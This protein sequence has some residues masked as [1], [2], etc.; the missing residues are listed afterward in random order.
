MNK[1][2]R[3]YILLKIA[4]KWEDLERE[5][6]QYKE[7][8]SLAKKSL[9]P[10]YALWVLSQLKADE[11]IAEIISLISTFEKRKGSLRNKDL[12]SYK[13]LGD[14]RG[15]IEELGVSKRIKIEE[16]KDYET[17]YKD[18]RFAIRLPKTK[19]GSCSLGRGTKWCISATESENYF[20][21]YS[22]AN[23]YIYFVFDKL[24]LPGTT[25]KVAFCY[26]KSNVQTLEPEYFDAKD[27]A[28]KY[29][30]IKNIYGDE[31]S[32]IEGLILSNLEG[33]E[34]TDVK[35]YY[36]SM[37]LD[38][39]VRTWNE[40][41]ESS[42]DNLGTFISS[43]LR[44]NPSNEICRFIAKNLHNVELLDSEGEIPWE[45]NIFYSYLPFDKIKEF[46]NNIN[47]PLLRDK[48]YVRVAFQY[49]KN[50]PETLSFE[51]VKDFILFCDKGLKNGQY[52]SDSSIQYLDKH[53]RNLLGKCS[54]TKDNLVDLLKIKGLDNSIRS[55]LLYIY[56]NDQFPI[57]SAKYEE[58]EE[59]EE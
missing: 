42:L 12:Y 11:P 16:G 22:A 21:R 7:D 47:L 20:D 46:I 44:S 19:E 15:A 25:D 50:N 8:L 13:S 6:G 53:L 9:P 17:I 37:S 30:D 2:I 28:L 32:K 31:L 41:K 5:N 40:L 24:G 54:A 3:N 29:N 35:K 18:D 33:K 48:E 1:F 34:D 38:E 59:D 14:L 55:E 4:G 58:P 10:A 51:Q 23:I 26:A 36:Q 39:F 57:G 56:N 43:S 27:N 45:L 49:F 52:F